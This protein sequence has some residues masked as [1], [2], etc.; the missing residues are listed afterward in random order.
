MRWCNYCTKKN[1]ACLWP[2]TGSKAR[3]CSQCQEHKVPCVVGEEGNKKRKEHGS[4]EKVVWK[5]TK[6][7][8]VVAWSSSSQ[9]ATLLGLDLS[10]QLI[11]RTLCDI[12]A[13]IKEVSSQIDSDWVEEK[14]LSS[15]TE[16]GSEKGSE[17][18]G[19]ENPT[20][21]MTLEEEVMELEVEA[22]GKEKA[23]SK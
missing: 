5:K 15:E 18:K 1:T 13:T 9:D 19:E 22:K 2:L 8:E 17:E 21:E 3:S 7:V 12:Y 20:E 11:H 4:P 23:K 10:Q 6:T 16:E 14:E